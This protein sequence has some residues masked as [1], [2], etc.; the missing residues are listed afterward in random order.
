MGDSCGLVDMEFQ[1]WSTASPI[2]GIR[3][4]ATPLRAFG[5]TQD[6]S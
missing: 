5:L 1:I 6:T 2:R 3:D 4:D